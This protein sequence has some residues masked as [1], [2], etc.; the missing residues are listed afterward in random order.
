MTMKEVRV[1]MGLTPVEIS[2][3]EAIDR[4]I[5]KSLWYV[6]TPF[7]SISGYFHYSTR[8][9]VL[10]QMLSRYRSLNGL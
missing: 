7:S 2:Y 9:G 4:E 10:S 5:A 3:C 8:Y 1:R 6:P